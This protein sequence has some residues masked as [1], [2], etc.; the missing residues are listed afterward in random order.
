MHKRIAEALLES[1][2]DRVSAIVSLN[3]NG[4]PIDVML[5]STDWPLGRMRVAENA[6]E[7]YLISHHPDG[8]MLPDEQDGLNYRQLVGMAGSAPVR[9][10]LASEYYPCFETEIS[11]MPKM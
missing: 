10:F 11:E 5:F 2:V 3:E 7:I 4:R 6:S 1:L 8:G 9:F